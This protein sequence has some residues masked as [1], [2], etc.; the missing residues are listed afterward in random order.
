MKPIFILI[1]LILGVAFLF[2]S[3]RY[4]MSSGKKLVFACLGVAFIVMTFISAYT[5]YIGPKVLTLLLR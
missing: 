1:F 3:S 4:P 2:F 5:V